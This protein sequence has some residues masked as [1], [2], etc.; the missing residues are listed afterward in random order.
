MTESD[1]KGLK[2]SDCSC[3]FSTLGGPSTNQESNPQ[4]NLV[5]YKMGR[6]G[7]VQV[8]LYPYEKGGGGVLA[9]L[10][11]GYNKVRGSFYAVA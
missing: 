10:K 7:G 5:S 6:G 8:K 4:D 1:N 2:P 9:M 3:C 11:E